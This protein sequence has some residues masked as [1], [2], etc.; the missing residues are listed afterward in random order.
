MVRFTAKSPHSDHFQKPY[1]DY[2][3]DDANT[4]T[5]DAPP[6]TAS[7]I[8]KALGAAIG[9]G[10][11][12]PRSEYDAAPS[13]RYDPSTMSRI[14]IDIHSDSVLDIDEM[15]DPQFHGGKEG[16]PGD[17]T[18]ILSGDDL[19]G[20]YQAQRMRRRPVYRPSAA[21]RRCLCTTLLFGGVMALVV[22]IT[23]LLVG[24]GPNGLS[25]WLDG[26][27]TPHGTVLPPAPSDLS[28]ICST[29]AI[30]QPGGYQKCE[31]ACVEAECCFLPEGHWFSCRTSEF[32]ARCASYEAD[33]MVLDG[34]DSSKGGGGGGNAISVEVP[35][36]PANLDE[37]CG[38]ASLG[39]ADG[40]DKCSDGCELARCCS[41]PIEVSIDVDVESWVGLN[42]GTACCNMTIGSRYDY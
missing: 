1:S 3:D 12:A 38:P 4:K 9:G 16:Q 18:F 33:C 23:H 28:T 14:G 8:K 5:S 40:Y 26:H 17:A 21:C 27:R 10:R 20:L 24:Y 22:G 32:G 30:G 2:V 7:K 39:T 34:Y 36:P 31:A 11:R 29:E 15:I 19:D 37:M 25:T 41:Q 35:A 13:S 6:N 42:C